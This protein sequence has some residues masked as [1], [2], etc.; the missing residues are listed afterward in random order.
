MQAAQRGMRCGILRIA[1][2]RGIG[3]VLLAVTLSR[4]NL[5]TGKSREGIELVGRGRWFAGSVVMGRGKERQG[6]VV[7]GVA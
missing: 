1:S 6:T 7:R 5:R 3:V 2:S 4:G